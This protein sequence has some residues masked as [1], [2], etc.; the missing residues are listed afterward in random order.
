MKELAHAAKVF[1][2][3]FARSRSLRVTCVAALCTLVAT[4]G[5][6]LV[7]A[8]LPAIVSPAQDE[9]GQEQQASQGQES[10][11]TAPSGTGGQGQGA[12][13]EGEAPAHEY[14]G[15]E[16][17]L[18][19]TLMGCSWTN[20]AGDVVTWGHDT[21]TLRSSSG[22]R[23]VAFELRNAEVGQAV[24]TTATENDRT[25]AIS[26][27]ETDFVL[28]WDGEP[29]S[30]TLVSSTSGEGTNYALECE[31]L[32]SMS[33]ATASA[34]LE[35]QGADGLDEATE[36]GEES[37]VEAIRSWCSTNA[38]LATRATWAGVAT[39]D[40]DAE[41]VSVELTLND[42]ASTV[43]TAVRDLDKGSWKIS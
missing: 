8:R 22:T 42:E 32:G 40:W 4:G 36:G 11:T 25:V 1:R 15:A 33:G 43:V 29:Y 31:P 38:P 24:G 41:T 5:V 12:T 10:P 9:Q 16:Q 2:D 27:V 21:V 30:A 19:D 39:R 13:S 20:R 37:L 7:L 17:G 34:E 6:A 23:T 35:I 3:T 14:S 18:L 28:V 26:T